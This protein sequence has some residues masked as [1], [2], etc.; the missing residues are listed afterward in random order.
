MRAPALVGRSGAVGPDGR[1]ER[2]ITSAPAGRPPAPQHAKR[3]NCHNAHSV[4][5]ER[6]LWDRAS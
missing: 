2:V 4:G 1:P 6:I 3:T 5:E